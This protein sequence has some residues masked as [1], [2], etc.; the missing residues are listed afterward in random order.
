MKEETL[1]VIAL[2][3]FLSTVL[4][5]YFFLKE[6]PNVVGHT[7]KDTLASL[8]MGIGFLG[9]DFLVKGF[10]LAAYAT[11]YQFRVFEMGD[12]I[13]SYL[14][15]LIALDFFY[16]WYHRTHHEIRILLGSTCQSSLFATL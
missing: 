6:R 12:S 15:L 3:F 14:G 5:E 13:W 2:P 8:S 11:A 7:L 9:W 16:Y 4:F 1:L 10:T